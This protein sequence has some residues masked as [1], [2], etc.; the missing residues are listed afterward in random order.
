MW[1][2][3]LYQ[4]LH[5]SRCKMKHETQ[6]FDIV[7]IN[8]HNDLQTL[9]VCGKEM[10][11]FLEEGKNLYGQYAMS[12]NYLKDINDEFSAQ[13]NE[14]QA[15]TTRLQQLNANIESFEAN[16]LK[17]HNAIRISELNKERVTKMFSIFR[18]HL[19]LKI[20]IINKELK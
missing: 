10:R 7:C 12:F 9:D 6:L 5:Q 20:N 2:L 4:I 14:I 19:L 3:P 18:E 17:V 8:V 15:L 1:S 16:M 11:R 13:M